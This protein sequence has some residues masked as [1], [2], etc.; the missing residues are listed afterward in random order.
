M[1]LLV[2]DFEFSVFIGYGRPRFF[3]P[4]I[5]EVGAV[6]L[7]PPYKEKELPYQT[8]V[9]PRYFPRITQECTDIT[10]IKQKDVD[11]GVDLAVVIDSLLQRY[12]NQTYFASWGTADR[13]TL[14]LNCQRYGLDYP[15]IYEN[16]I[17]LSEEYMKFYNLPTRKSVKKALDQNNII[18]Q[19]ILHAALD[20]AVNEALIVQKMLS[21]G[22]K[23]ERNVE[24]ITAC[25]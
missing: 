6:L 12:D 14:M 5:I 11:G 18:P 17:D 20:D 23:I 3:F 10:L 1:N 22:W 2:I 16:Y 8:F 7:K 19:G 21:E 24:N 15:F 13:D 9:K 4:E 25:F